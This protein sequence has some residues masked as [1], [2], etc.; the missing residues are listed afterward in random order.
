M[1]IYTRIGDKGNTTLS[2]GTKVPKD[3]FRIEACG[4]VDEL[5]SW[6]G[7]IH[8]Q[9]IDDHDKEVIFKIQGL[10]MTISSHLADEKKTLDYPS[11]PDDRDIEWIEHEIDVIEG[12]VLPLEAFIVPGG[13][14]IVAY[15]HVARCICRRAER[16]LVPVLQNR[17]DTGIAMKL[18]NRLSDYLFMLCRKI[19][20][21]LN[22]EEKIWN[23]LP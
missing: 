12:L 2:G 23:P 17:Q 21:D 20:M 11:L 15:C 19:S 9:N 1:K 14:T 22:C 7:L 18:L 8:S 3:D 6:L 4:T 13:H 5:V 10:L 16:R